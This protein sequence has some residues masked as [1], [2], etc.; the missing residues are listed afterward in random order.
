MPMGTF[1]GDRGD[2]WYVDGEVFK[3]A[4]ED[5]GVCLHPAPPRTARAQVDPYLSLLEKG[6]KGIVKKPKVPGSGPGVLLKYPGV[7]SGAPPGGLGGAAAAGGAPGG[8]GVGAPGGAAGG[9]LGGHAGGAMSESECA[10]SVASSR[11]TD[12]EE[13]E[14]A[15]GHGPKPKGGP[16]HFAPFG[17]G[18]ILINRAG[19]SLDA[20][21]YKCGAGFDRSWKERKGARQGHTKAQGRPLGAELAWLSLD[22]DGDPEWHTS[23]FSNEGLPRQRRKDCRREALASGDFAEFFARERSPRGS[24]SEGEPAAVPTRVAA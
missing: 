8:A 10:E 21:C 18:Q 9:P 7:G 2:R 13:W 5:G 17:N 23:Q 1:C 6:I 12:Q 24:E 14:A 15:A 20:L 3:S 19:N 4:L 11:D 16:C 22:C